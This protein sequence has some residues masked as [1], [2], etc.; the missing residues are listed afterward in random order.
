[1]RGG[2][3]QV[4]GDAGHQVGAA[5]RG[6]R[7]GMCGGAILVHGSA[8][9]EIGST[10]RRGLIAIGGDAGDFAGVSMIA[11]TVLLFGAA[12]IRSGAGMKRGTIVHFGPARGRQPLQLLST[13]RFDC[14]YQPVF[15]RIL[16]GRLR[17]HGFAV[18]DLVTG[19]YRRFSGDV[20]ALGKGEVL[21][22]KS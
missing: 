14:E 18:N 15:M 10:M 8:G 9:N 22:W 4:K 11:G 7:R 12:G 19:S 5:Y 2:L 3:I 17:R 6:S 16:L 21:L 20:V 1:M 13:F